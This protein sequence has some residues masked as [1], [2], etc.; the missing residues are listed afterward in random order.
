MTPFRLYFL[1]L[2]TTPL[3]LN[4]G[5]HDQIMPFRLKDSCQAAL[6]R[7]ADMVVNKLDVKQGGK[8]PGIISRHCR[9][10]LVVVD[11]QELGTTRPLITCRRDVQ[12]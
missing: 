4:L 6:Q 10:T 12:L 3:L 2:Q 5:G 11:V 1:E 7:L 8:D 9:E